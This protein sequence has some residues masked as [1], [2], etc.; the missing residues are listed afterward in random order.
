MALDP[1]L[2]ALES[3]WDLDLGFLGRLRMGVFEESGAAR[4][5]ELI[6]S[7]PLPEGETISRRLVSLLWFAPEFMTWQLGRV[8]EAAGDVDSVERWRDRITEAI[9]RHFGWP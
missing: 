5:L 8:R 1:Y 2:E 9:A 4:L 6:E 3:E 7:I